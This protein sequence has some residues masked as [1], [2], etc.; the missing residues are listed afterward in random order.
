MAELHFP[1][2]Q[3]KTWKAVTSPIPHRFILSVNAW[4]GALL[5]LSG[6]F[7]HSSVGTQVCKTEVHKCSYLIILKGRGIT[8]LKFEVRF[9]YICIEVTPFNY[10]NCLKETSSTLQFTRVCVFP[11]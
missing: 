10:M 3:H 9:Y 1:V 8:S 7:A 2:L 11:F 4:G 6:H 5:T